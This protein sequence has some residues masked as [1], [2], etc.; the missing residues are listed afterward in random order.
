M[1]ITIE[2]V[3]QNAFKVCKKFNFNVGGVE[4]QNNRYIYVFLGQGGSGV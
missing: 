1:K 2:C 4:M 3:N